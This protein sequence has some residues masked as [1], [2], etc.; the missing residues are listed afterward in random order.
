MTYRANTDPDTKR[1]R[2]MLVL[3]ALLF[4]V[5]GTG[6]YLALRPKPTVEERIVAGFAEAKI[7]AQKG[8]ISGAVAIVSPRFK[9]GE[10]DK[11]R[12]RLLLFQARR[13]YGKT[14]WIVD[15]TPPRIL[16]PT[17]DKPNERLVLT[18]VVARASTGEPLWSTGSGTI[19]LLMREE[20]VKTWG[21]FPHQ[22]WRIVAAPSIPGL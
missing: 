8:D 14:D 22:E 4:A 6:I 16:P 17:A 2:L 20:T 15:I 18:R 13:E 9:A 21:I 3:F 19:T 10:V 5:G 7:A 1:R 12:L 11:K